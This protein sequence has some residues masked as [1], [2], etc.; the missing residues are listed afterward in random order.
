MG[1]A[2]AEFVALRRTNQIKTEQ[3]ELERAITAQQDEAA[4][5]GAN[6]ALRYQLAW[7]Q[8]IN[9]VRRADIEGGESI[10]RS[11]VKIADQTVYHAQQANAKVLEFIASQKGITDIAAD[12]KI[13]LMQRT[14]DG[15]DSA[16]ERIVPQGNAFL[17]IL[18]EMVA[19]LLK[20][21]ASKVF[22]KLFGLETGASTGGERQS[23]GIFSGIRS[24]FGGGNSG[25][26]GGG[27]LGGI[28]NFLTGGF[29]GGASPAGAAGAAAL[30]THALPSL[31][32]LAP[33][34]GLSAGASAAGAAA[35]T[36]GAGA[37]AGGAGAAGGA[38]A[39]G[40]GLSMASMGAF[41]T[42]P[43]TIGVA[44]AAI[45]GFLLWKH[46]SHGTEKA[47]R[48]AIRS[49]YQV[50]VRDMNVLTQFKQVGEQ[51]FGRGR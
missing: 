51:A 37:A 30:P 7:V 36:G 5:M 19:S 10:I 43:I 50:D 23:G 45:G 8:S 47:L 17:S 1:N 20:L 33:Q 13:G 15:I 3:L 21:A 16:L 6:A 48:G 35:I 27:L 49:E 11:Q 18:K 26:G 12:V 22:M 4:T 39:A 2:D 32:S 34:V 29:G 24:L 46:F 25:G 40:G 44:A 41:L 28:R 38:A 9:E 31:A 42:N 14:F